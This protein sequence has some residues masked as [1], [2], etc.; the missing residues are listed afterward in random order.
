MRTRSDLPLVGFHS[1]PFDPMGGGFSVALS[2][3][4]GEILKQLGAVAV[5]WR[6]WSCIVPGKI[7]LVSW[8]HGYS[9]SLGI[10]RS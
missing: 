5:M 9:S 2:A 7:S 3:T 8:G 6:I 1:R 10:K 4:G